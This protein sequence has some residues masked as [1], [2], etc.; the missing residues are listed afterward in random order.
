MTHIMHI[1]VSVRLRILRRLKH[2][3]VI[4]KIVKKEREKNCYLVKEE[5]Y[6]AQQRDKRNMQ[7]VLE[8]QKN[9]TSTGE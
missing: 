2:T 6:C 1:L 8:L 4:Y 9:G 3:I 7:K 5:N